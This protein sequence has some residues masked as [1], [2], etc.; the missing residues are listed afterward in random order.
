MDKYN[1][2]LEKIK[3][4]KATPEEE[5]ALLDVLNVSMDAFKVLLEEVKKKQLEDKLKV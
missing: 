3:S 4:G 1:E 2:L 5:M